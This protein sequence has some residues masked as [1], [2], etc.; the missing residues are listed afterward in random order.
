MFRLHPSWK[1]LILEKE[2]IA[3]SHQTGHNSGVVHSGIYYKPGSLKAKNCLQGR[4]QLLAFC[5][6]HQIPHKKIHKLIVAHRKE[7]IPRLREIQSRGEAHQIPGLRRLNQKEVLEIEPHVEAV[8]ALFLPECHIVDYKQVARVLIDELKKQGVEI[9]CNEEV[10]EVKKE[11]ANCFIHTNRQIL[12]SSTFIN[13]AG[14]H[15][16]RLVNSS[17]RILPFRGEYY[18]IA[19]SQRN[20]VKGLIYPVPDPRFPFLGV[21]LTPMID[22]R[23]KAGP[24]AILALSREG[25]KKGT[26]N[27]KDLWET[28]TYTGFWKMALRYWKAGLYEI[29]RAASVTLFLR[30]LQQLVPSLKEKDLLPGPSGVR[31][32]L[33]TREGRLLD[34]F[35]F[36]REGNILHVLNAPS[37]AATACFSIGQTLAEMVS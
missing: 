28:L 10:L 1:I 11:G 32:Q 20:I 21:H 34:D 9:L 14:L 23:L 16:D 25:Y 27:R 31:A 5:E 26:L 24:N 30:D 19:P 22:G 6:R 2:P 13:C 18:E 33:V 15:S 12:S 8:E 35:A 3:A 29:A 17:H 4:K 7:Q 37:P 36:H